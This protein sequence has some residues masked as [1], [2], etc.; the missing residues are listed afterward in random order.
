[1]VE[2]RS[3]ES[4]SRE[5]LS[6][7]EVAL[8]LRRAAELEAAADPADPTRYDPAAVEAAASEVGLSPAAVRQAI[9]ELRVGSL[10]RPPGGRIRCTRASDVVVDQR[11]VAGSPP[12]VLDAVT[13]LLRAHLFEPGR[14]TGD[15]AVFRPREDLVAKLQRRLDFARAVRLDGVASVTVVATEADGGTLVR[16]EAALARTRAGIVTGSAG[17]GAGVGLLLG[18]GGAL[19]HEPALIIGAPPAAVVLAAGG[20]RRRGQRWEQ[21]RERVADALAALLDRL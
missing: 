17:M 10:G 2:S 12:A 19:F 21:Q 9:A 20:I 8:V 6:S 18:L 1:M 3:R 7:D 14:R 11:P 5:G 15:R 4:R 13:R 16:A